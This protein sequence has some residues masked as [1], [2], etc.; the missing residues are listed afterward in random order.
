M[1]DVAG[2]IPLAEAPVPSKPSLS[3]RN[4]TD[5]AGL[6]SEEYRRREERQRTRERN[7]DKIDK[8]K[9]SGIKGVFKKLF[10]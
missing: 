10:A 6:S 5:A 9:A 3:A 7:D 8:K 4:T 2:D 1:N